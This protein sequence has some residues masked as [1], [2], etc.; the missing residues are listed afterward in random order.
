MNALAPDYKALDREC[1]VFSMYLIGLPPSEYV[2]E[3][4]R[5]AHQSRCHFSATMQPA[6]K[7]LVRIAS[8]APWST[9]IIDV[10][11]RIFRPYSTVR[12]KL[13]L[14]LAILESCAPSH[15]YLDTA[16]VNSTFIL[17]LSLVSRCAVFLLIVVLSLLFILPAELK[18]RS[19]AKRVVF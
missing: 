12:K 17:F 15:T 5:A 14:L 2:M 3:K 19:N 11:S 16:D 1:S 6:E 9:K 8:I 4:Y 18:L 13:V 7:F 10:Y